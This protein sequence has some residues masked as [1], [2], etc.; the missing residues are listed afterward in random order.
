MHKN[1]TL[2]GGLFKLIMQEERQ[3]RRNP[4][5]LQS[6]TNHGSSRPSEH[7]PQSSTPRIASD[8]IPRSRCRLNP[9]RRRSATSSPT[10]SSFKALVLRQPCAAACFPAGA[11]LPCP[12]GVP[13]G[14]ELSSAVL[15]T[16][17]SGGIPFCLGV[18]SD[19]HGRARLQGDAMVLTRHNLLG[20]PPHGHH[21]VPALDRFGGWRRL[22]NK[23]L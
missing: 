17:C 3:R 21:A 18:R 23:C 5:D 4:P 20:V 14:A 11:E 16:F 10:T 1:R 19:C 8:S 6:E 22:V 9:S 7:V 12:A 15:P 2:A 13:A